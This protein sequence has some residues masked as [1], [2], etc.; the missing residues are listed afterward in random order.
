MV[1]RPRYVP[2]LHGRLRNG[3]ATAFYTL[4]RTGGTAVRD[5][6]QAY[7]AVLSH[8]WQFCWQRKAQQEPSRRV[9]PHV[10]STCDVEL[11]ASYIPRYDV[12]KD[13]R[14]E[15]ARVILLF[16]R[17]SE[18]AHHVD[19]PDPILLPGGSSSSARCTVY[20]LTP[21]AIEYSLCQVVSNR[22]QDTKPND[23]CLNN[24][25]ISARAK[26]DGNVLLRS[27]KPRLAVYA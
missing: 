25:L 2:A 18:E 14:G 5:E 13:I 21:A 8:A 22:E 27:G 19:G 10:L 9:F 12:S 1:E 16:R 11:H 4:R 3:P 15:V 20:T 23:I 24:S 7:W 26:E 6:Q 17:D